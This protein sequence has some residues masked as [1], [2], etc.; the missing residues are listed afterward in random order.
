MANHGQIAIAETLPRALELAAEV[1][2]LAAQYVLALTV[3]KPVLLS[4]AEMADVLDRFKAYGQKAQE[5]PA[6]P[7]RASAR[8]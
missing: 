3:G 6:P 1:E 4:K 2:Q 7:K 5:A 8:R